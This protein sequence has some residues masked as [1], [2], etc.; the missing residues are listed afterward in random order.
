MESKLFTTIIAVGS[1]GFIGS[2]LRYLICRFV[3]SLFNFDFPI[4][5]I[6][7]NVIGCLC[8]GLITGLIERTGGTNQT[9]VLLLVTGFCGGFT[10]F[11]TFADDMLN[12][13]HRNEW[14][15]FIICLVLSLVLGVA[16]VALGRYVVGNL[17]I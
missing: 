10:T 5:T 9:A 8:I 12:L 13:L 17:N 7:V 15:L 3:H 1:G 2:V 11:S 14:S 16:M 6:V 4:G